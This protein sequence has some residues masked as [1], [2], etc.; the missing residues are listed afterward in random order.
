MILFVQLCNWQILAD[1]TD[2]RKKQEIDQLGKGP[3]SENGKDMVK[4]E[5]SDGGDAQGAW[6]YPFSKWKKDLP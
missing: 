3:H 5:K 6:G 2:L 4:D 1:E